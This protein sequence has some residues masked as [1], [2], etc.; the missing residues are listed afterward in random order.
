MGDWV[1]V[2][3][4][5]HRQISASKKIYSKLTARYYGPFQI[6]APIGEVAYK[7]SLPSTS[8]I[9][10]VFHVS[11]LKKAIGDLP[12]EKELPPEWEIE[13]APKVELE[14]ILSTREVTRKGEKFEEW[15]IRWKERP[16][17]DASWERAI[18]IQNQFPTFCLE[19][20]AAS[21][22]EGIDRNI[23]SV[24]NQA[25]LTQPKPKIL[26]VYSRRPKGN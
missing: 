26:K 14:A 23:S 13:A 11:Q 7:L 22:G 4:R 1:Y 12:A 18:N 24:Q 19:D 6:E 9:H 5:P 25:E 15:L 16:V 3:L 2:K 20:K 8:R 21:V 10:P 17:E